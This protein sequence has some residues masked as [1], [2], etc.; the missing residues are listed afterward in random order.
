M[1][2]KPRMDRDDN[3]P[4][5]ALRFLRRERQMS[6]LQVHGFPGEPDC[7]PQA[8]ARQST[9]QDGRY[10]LIGG[11]FQKCGEFAVGEGMPFLSDFIVQ[12]HGCCGIGSN[13]SLAACL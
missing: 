6:S 1:G 2:G 3:S 4:A 9:Q 8:K 11:S 7:I 13:Q 5:F 10:P 12:F